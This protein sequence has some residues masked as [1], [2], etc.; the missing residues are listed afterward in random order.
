MHQQESDQVPS[1]LDGGGASV[2]EGAATPVAPAAKKRRRKWPI[3]VGVCAAVLVVAGTGFMMW[4]EQPSV[5]NAICHS[6][7][8]PYVEGYYEDATLSAYAHQVENVTCLECHEPKLDEQI[9]EGLHWVAGD[10]EVDETGML[11][12]VGVRS[13]A[14]MC[15]RQGCHDFDEV[16]AATENWGGEAGVNPHD[17]HQ[18][19]AIDCSNCHV[20]HGQSVMYCNTCHDYEVPEG[21]AAPAKSADAASSPAAA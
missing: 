19:Y 1:R 18:G 12:T 2:A 20:V 5:C 14:G 15:T 11:K 4:H 8:D 6:P 9:E 13:D 21:W 16:V 7:M 10:F 17:S 3:V